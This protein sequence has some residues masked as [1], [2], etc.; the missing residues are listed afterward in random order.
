MKFG[1]MPEDPNFVVPEDMKDLVMHARLNVHGSSVMFSDSMPNAP[2]TIGKNITLAVVSNDLEKLEKDF[3]SLAKEGNVT[4][5]LQETF[6]SPS[7][8]A[9]EDKFGVAWQ[10]SFEESAE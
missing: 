8:G 5:P 4:M 9:L 6:W 7:Y 10:F 2:V 3:N 1:G